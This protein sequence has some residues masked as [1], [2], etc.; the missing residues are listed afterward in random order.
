MDIVQ[1][2][3]ENERDTAVR[4]M[5]LDAVASTLTGLGS[6]ADKALSLL[7]IDTTPFSSSS[8]VYHT[9]FRSSWVARKIVQL[10]PGDMLRRWRKFEGL[11]EEKQKAVRQ[12]EDEIYLRRALYD[13][14]I[15]TRRN[16]GAVLLMDLEDNRQP[17]ESIG[18]VRRIRGLYPIERSNVT[19]MPCDTFLSYYPFG[20]EPELYYIYGHPV[21]QSRVIPFRGNFLPSQH[22]S[23]DNYFFGES[24][25]APIF[26]ELLQNMSVRQTVAQLVQEVGTPIYQLQNLW[27]MLG[28][29][30]YQQ[31]TD[32]LQFV[33]S[34]KSTHNAV[35][36][37]LADKLELLQ[38]QFNGLF[39]TMKEF[40]EPI[41]AA[42]DIPMTRFWGSSPGGLNATGESDIRNY[43]DSLE[44]QRG[45]NVDPALTKL[46]PILLPLAGVEPDE[47]YEWPPLWQPTEKEQAEN[48]RTQA[49]AMLKKAMVLRTL[50]DIGARDDELAAQAKEWGLLP[51][52]AGV[53]VDL[54][55]PFLNLEGMEHDDLDALAP[56]ST[57]AAQPEPGEPE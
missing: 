4:R 23:E 2:A 9:L 29:K 28:T 1:I 44:D 56:L 46:D 14:Q 27:A 34:T 37:D 20:K 41:C 40:R 21:H 5:A 8:V 31:L 38:V 45:Q 35:I 51:E 30:Q 49:D 16:G 36:L 15:L 47:P 42:A 32:Y 39:Q 43:Y 55:A 10:P 25:L 48:E 19:V 17:H 18:N 50:F 52:Q 53:D 3:A 6:N 22:Q 54:S 26:E 24:T 13:V 12:I 7:P 33:N 57:E 11:D